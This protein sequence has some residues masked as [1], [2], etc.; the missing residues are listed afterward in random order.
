MG[1][2]LEPKTATSPER[3]PPVMP[4][5]QSMTAAGTI[6]LTFGVILFT[7]G[8]FSGWNLILMVLGLVFIAAGYSTRQKPPA[9][10]CPACRMEVPL[11]ASV[12]GH[13]QRD[14]PA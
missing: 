11:E 14:I 13:C 2:F 5:Q 4:K 6:G 3:K 9:K 8:S 1:L 12:C 7:L 10:L